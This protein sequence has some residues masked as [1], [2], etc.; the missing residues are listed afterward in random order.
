MVFHQVS[1]RFCPNTTHKHVLPLLYLWVIFKQILLYPPVS[2]LT[3]EKKKKSDFVL[4]QFLQLA[5][6]LQIL[7]TLFKAL[8]Q[9]MLNSKAIMLIKIHFAKSPIFNHNQA[10]IIP[11]HIVF[12]KDLP[13]EPTSI[14]YSIVVI[15]FLCK[16]VSLFTKVCQ[17]LCH[18]VIYYHL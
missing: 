3:K 14:S 1:H 4:M 8:H 9:P 13:L 7:T 6:Y 12:L 17:Y 15:F 11:I 10:V 18:N 2:P 5:K 16:F